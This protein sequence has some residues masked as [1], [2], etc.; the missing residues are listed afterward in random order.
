MNKGGNRSSK[1]IAYTN[2][3][4]GVLINLKTFRQK[5]VRLFSIITVETKQ[6][7]NWELHQKIWELIPKKLGIG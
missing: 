5:P 2:K 7:K 6:A 3:W 4:K 1:F